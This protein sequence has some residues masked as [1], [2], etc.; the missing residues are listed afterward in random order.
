[1]NEFDEIVGLDTLK[2]IHL[3]DSKS[4][5]DSHVDRHE[6][7]GLG[8]IGIQGLRTIINNKSLRDLP[9]VMQT[10]IDSTRNNSKN[11]EVVL[12]LRN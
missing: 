5:I 11:L 12:K 4:E 2:F 3:N 8:K 9:M 10:P 6:H 7:I 1:M